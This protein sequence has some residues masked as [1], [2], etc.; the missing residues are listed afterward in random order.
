VAGIDDFAPL[1]VDV[2]VDVAAP[3]VAFGAHVRRAIEPLV[4]R[5]LLKG[6]ISGPEVSAVGVVVTSR[7]RGTGPTP[8]IGAFGSVNDPGQWPGKPIKVQYIAPN[9][10][11]E[12]Q[13][14]REIQQSRIPRRRVLQ[15][16]KYLTIRDRP[17]DAPQKPNRYFTKGARL[18]L[19]AKATDHDSTIVNNSKTSSQ[20]PR[21]SRGSRGSPCLSLPT[22]RCRSKSSLVPMAPASVIK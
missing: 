10:G 19:P 12:V 8:A 7:V 11:T 9:N 21:E 18:T 2:E 4:V 22:R 15:G 1:V 5:G 3:L 6:L 16:T 13:W 17:I 20:C 14:R